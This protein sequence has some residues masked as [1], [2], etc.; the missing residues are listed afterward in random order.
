MEEIASHSG[1]VIGSIELPV[2]GYIF[3]GRVCFY[4]GRV[5]PTL[6]SFQLFHTGGWIVRLAR[7]VKE[8]SA[9]HSG[10]VRRATAGT[11]EGWQA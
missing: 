9:G 6:W 2:G 5:E 1:M 11:N 7:A 10:L 3:A 4:A 8:P